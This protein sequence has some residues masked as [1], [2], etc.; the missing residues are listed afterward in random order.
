M[1]RF[2]I[3]TATTSMTSVPK[4]LKYLAEYYDAIKVGYN[5]IS[6][7]ATKKLYADIISVLAISTVSS[8]ENKE[9]RDCLNFCLQGSM[10][11][12]GD[13]GHEYI[14]FVVETSRI[15]KSMLKLYFIKYTNI[16]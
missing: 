9:K 10:C 2:L 6:D 3:R 7:P 4:P 16:K 12:V 15:F 1:M 14:R 11:D 13:W 8:D 5:K